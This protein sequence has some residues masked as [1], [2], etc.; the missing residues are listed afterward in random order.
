MQQDSPEQTGGVVPAPRTEPTSPSDRPPAIDETVVL[1]AFV[2]GKKER[3]PKPPEP[4][5]HQAAPDDALPPSERGMLIF[6]A[7]LL[8]VGTL[9]MVAMLGVG[10]F[11]GA[12][13]APKASSSATA[14]TQ[15]PASYPTLSPTPE[16]S[17]PAPSSP[18]P[19][20]PAP[21]RT[22]TPGRIAL[23]TL[24]SADPAAFCTY[25][26][27]GRARQR[28]GTW[29]CS[30][31]SDHP[32]FAFEPTDVCRWRYLDRTAYAVLGDP[33]DPATWRCYT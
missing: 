12:S 5:R 9:A 17:S 11:G 21:T 32:P 6:V 20:S 23:G 4:V 24:T 28:D 26:K 27:A 8:G 25:S 2:T 22:T 15:Q 33:R 19:P 18:P 14:A 10:G 3:E 31:T 30:G 29:Y 13:P 1:P 7:A 16:V